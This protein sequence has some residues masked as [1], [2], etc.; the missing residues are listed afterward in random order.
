M[1]VYGTYKLSSYRDHRFCN[2]TLLY[3]FTVNDMQLVLLLIQM[4]RESFVVC[5]DILSGSLHWT[6]CE[7]HIS[8]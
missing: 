7:F 1:S 6:A 3:E 8:L 4:F 2:V 5:R